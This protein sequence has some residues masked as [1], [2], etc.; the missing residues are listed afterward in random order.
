MQGGE[1]TIGSRVRYSRT[2]TIGNVVRF[3][4]QKG[5]R[6]AELD[7]THLLYRLDQL[8]VTDGMEK[9]RKMRRED[10]VRQIEKEREYVAGS[11]YAEALAHTDQSCEGGG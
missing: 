8:T 11:A 1:I 3:E 10:T 2:G 4:E 6:F 5:A 7:S 9:K